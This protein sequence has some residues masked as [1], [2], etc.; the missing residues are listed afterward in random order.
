MSPE[1]PVPTMATTDSSGL[2]LDA[3]LGT[4]M[5][6]IALAAALGSILV[7][8][9]VTDVLAFLDGYRPGH[10]VVMSYARAFLVA[11]A[12]W[13]LLAL[14]AVGTLDAAWTDR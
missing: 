5:I 8:V 13:G 7:A 3:G 14:A 2:V 1:S 11:V 6:G 9:G 4:T 10:W 12:G